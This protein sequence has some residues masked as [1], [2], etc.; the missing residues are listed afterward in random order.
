MVSL[1]SL[2]MYFLPLYA[3]P[4]TVTPPPLPKLHPTYYAHTDDKNIIVKLRCE[5]GN[6]LTAKVKG[7]TTMASVKK[8]WAAH[9]GD[10]VDKVRLTYDGHTLFDDDRTME[11]CIRD[12]GFESGDVME[13][14]IL[15]VGS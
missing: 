14:S 5:V 8:A 6:V 4:L 13:V 9:K 11:D 12:F 2:C 3:L 10:K 15:Q 7:S 1:C